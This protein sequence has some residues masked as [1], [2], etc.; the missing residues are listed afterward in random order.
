MIVALSNFA[1]HAYVS[2]EAIEIVSGHH[3]PRWKSFNSKFIDALS[4]RI[5]ILML[6]VESDLYISSSRCHGAA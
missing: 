1:V 2:S 5:I 4:D 6:L 3:F